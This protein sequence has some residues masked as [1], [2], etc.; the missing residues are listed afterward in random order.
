MRKYIILLLF[1]ALM[2]ACVRLPFV[3]QTPTPLPGWRSPVY[4]LLLEDSSFPEGW[5]DEFPNET[6]KDPTINHVYR[7][8]GRGYLPGT[9]EQSI[10][11]AYTEE[12]AIKTYQNLQSQFTPTPSVFD[13]VFIPLESPEEVSFVSE[14]ADEWKFACG[15][16]T[17]PFCVLIARYR[18]YTTEMRLALETEDILNPGEL[19]DGLT[20]LEIE[21]VL[22]EVDLKFSE[23]LIQNPQ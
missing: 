22:Q 21:N 8:W 20:Y 11:R 13:D 6:E 2:L 5:K 15:W 3:K 12:R 9:V 17:I 16:Q 19:T 23:F 10:Q 7:I 14:V 1:V 4:Q 18:N